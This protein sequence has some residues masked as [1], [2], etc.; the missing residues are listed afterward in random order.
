MTGGLLTWKTDKIKCDKETADEWE[1][2]KTK[3]TKIR[4]LS[5]FN[6]KYPWDNFDFDTGY[7]GG[8]ASEK[9][10]VNLLIRFNSCVDGITPYKCFNTDSICFK[11]N[12]YCGTCWVTCR[13]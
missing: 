7:D 5:L 9:R 12:C 3:A 10:P 11:P 4:L 8:C 1:K 2:L 6:R 13:N